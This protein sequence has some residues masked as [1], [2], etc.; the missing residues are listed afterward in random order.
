MNRWVFVRNLQNLDAPRLRVK[1]CESFSCRLR[2]YTFQRE[3]SEDEGILLVQSR[4][5]RIDTSIHMLAVFFDLTVLWLDSSL[6]IVDK[7]LAKKWA[8]SYIPK[9]PAQYV[10]EIHPAQW[11]FFDIGD[12]L[13]LEEI[14]H[15]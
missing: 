8:L 12:T 15:D 10:L 7:K 11:A 4:E 2:G 14:N 5:S 6:K 3:M 9:A 1:Y 13:S